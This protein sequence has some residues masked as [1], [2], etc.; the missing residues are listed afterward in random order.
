[1]IVKRKIV[2]KPCIDLKAC[3]ETYKA[4]MLVFSEMDNVKIKYLLHKNSVVEFI[5]ESSSINL[6][7]FFMQ[8]NIYC[9]DLK[10]IRR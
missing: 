1:M 2:V 7:N 6:D 8:L 9:Y 4:V 5:F 3:A 10:D